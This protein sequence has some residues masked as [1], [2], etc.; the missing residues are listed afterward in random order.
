M[1]LTT[2]KALFPPLNLITVAAL[3]P[4][5][6]E[7]RLAD[8]NLRAVSEEEWNWA[9]LVMFSAMNVQ[10]EDCLEQIRE[11][12]RRGKRVAVGGMYP[13]SW[14][15]EAE[16]VGADYLILNEG[17]ITISPFIQALQ[18]GETQG[19]FSAEGQYPDLAQ[20]PTPRFDLLELNAYE[21]A[22]VQFSRGCPFQCEFCDITSLYGRKTRAKT[23]E[24]FL[25]EL[26][27]LRKSGWDRG[28][29]VVDDN[30]IGDKTRARA[31]LKQ[32]QAWQQKHGYPFFFS[33]EASVNLAHEAELLNLMVECGFNAVFLGI[34]TPDEQTLNAAHKQQNTRA[35]IAEAV[36]K[37]T[38][39]GLRV[40]GAFI[41]GFDGETA[42]AGRR[43]A[44][45]VEQTSIP[46]AFLSILQALPRAALWKRLQQ[47]N[48]LLETAAT[49]VMNFIPT[50]PAEEIGKEYIEAVGEL[51]EPRRFLDRVYR[52]F[53]ILGAPRFKAASHAPRWSDIHAL[54]FILWRQGVMRN[55]RWK[56]WRYLLC[57]ALKNPRV[58]KHYLVV[59]AHIEHLF[60]YQKKVQKEF[61]AR[62]QRASTHGASN[63]RPIGNHPETA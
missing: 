7:L 39:A 32:L 53:L 29:F 13:T 36:E 5:E 20:S 52:H 54:F 15:Q 56:F 55:T 6:W 50:R 41:L 38:C 63:T 9:E 60:P 45:F 40:M 51:Y 10:K 30:F 28:V 26:D 49:G 21:T 34:E 42:G 16:A 23:P 46:I 19:R 4:K 59:C 18:R 61:T 24:Q 2:R 22:S 47:E 48:R 25:A 44:Q 1:E 12:K 58:V 17:E 33:T 31:L 14:P 62:L 37:I 35:P 8:R 57:L 27:V 43:I 11:A 3:L